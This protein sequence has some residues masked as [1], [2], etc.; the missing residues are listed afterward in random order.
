M[1]V[2]VFVPTWICIHSLPEV[3]HGKK[4][5]LVLANKQ[6]SFVDSSAVI[7]LVNLSASDSKPL[8]AIIAD[9]WKLYMKINIK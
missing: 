3:P 7:L 5:A 1:H 6:P 9:K 2:C 8:E 4:K